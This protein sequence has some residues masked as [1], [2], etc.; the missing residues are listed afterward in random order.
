MIDRDYVAGLIIKEADKYVGQ[1]ETDGQNRSELIDSINKLM[2]ANLGSP[3]CQS[4]CYY[5]V[6]KVCQKNG[7]INPLPKTPSTQDA[8]YTS[9]QKYVKRLGSKSDIAYWQSTTDSSRGHAGLLR[10][11]QILHHFKTIEFNTDSTGSREGGGVWYKSRTITGTDSLSFLG[12]VDVAQWIL[13][14]NSL[15]PSNNY[16]SDFRLA[17]G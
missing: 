3:Y 17:T 6:D 15:L 1:K 4:G 10:E 5:V 7:W 8:W 14:S 2:Q 12:F 11:D 13:D 9:D 16:G